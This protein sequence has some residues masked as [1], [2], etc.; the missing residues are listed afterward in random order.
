MP[1]PGDSSGDVTLATW[2]ENVR[3]HV[4]GDRA[5]QAN[6][7]ANGYAAGS[8]TITTSYDLGAIAAGA[9]VTNGLNTMRVFSA[10]TGTK[11]AAVRAGWANSVDADGTAG[12][13]LRVNPRFTD[14]GI[15]TA[16]NDTLASLSAPENGLFKVGTVELAFDGVVQGY[17]LSGISDPLLRVLEVR[18]AA[19]DS[20]V[21]WVRLRAGEWSLQRSAPTEDFAS[22][23]ALRITAPCVPATTIQVVYAAGFTALA[24]LTDDVTASGIPSTATDIPPL[25]A[26]IRLMAGREIERNAP[27][28]Q[29]DSRRAQEVPPGAVG[30]SY[31]G[32]VGL[33]QQRVRE[34]AVRLRAQYPTGA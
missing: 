28:S 13:L 25:G 24:A 5:E 26:A 15:F 2:I 7:L 29:G 6:I 33:F 16:L 1:I 22:G 18:R 14:H 11:T 3:S 19:T 12:D 32:L 9:I 30:R 31:G 8:E 27:G 10:N 21:A 20:T 17:D 34:E 4:D 23:A